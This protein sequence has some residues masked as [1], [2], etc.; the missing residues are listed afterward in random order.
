VI[1]SQEKSMRLRDAL[2]LG[3]VLVLPVVALGA[4]G[5][6]ATPDPARLGAG[7]VFAVM[8]L[9]FTGPELGP[10]DTPAR[11]VH[12]SVLFRHESGSPSYLVQGYWDGD[13]RGGVRGGVF[14]V[15]F[16]PTR[17]GRWYLAEVRSNRKELDGQRE[18]S[19]V[20]A[21]P[22]RNHGFWE[23]DGTSA[24]RRWYRRSDGSHQYVVGNTFYS[25]LSETYLDGKPNGS[26]IARDVRGNAAYFKKLRFSP[27][28]DRYPAPH[29]APF[30]DDSGR[31]TYDGNYSHRP[32]PAWFHDRVDVAV[33]TAFDADLIADLIAS[34]VDTEDARSALRPSHNG[35]DAEPFLR[36][37]A[38]RYGAY[39]NVWFCLINEY[40]IQTPHYT[41]DEIRALGHRLRRYLPYPTPVSVHR[42][43]GPWPTALNDDPSWNDH[44][45]V[46]E[47]LR[48]LSDAADF[49]AESYARGGAD[50][51]VID[52]ELSYQGAG[53]GHDELDTIEAHLGAFLG[54]GYGTTGYKSAN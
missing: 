48:D 35:G 42:S 30:L 36:Y 34:G 3:A 26:D 13:G 19:Y 8:E 23:V 17:P 39:P 49:V 38:A 16:T 1:L 5:S 18:D 7:P 41:A 51:P 50:R 15:R 2:V 31:P 40:D 43:G 21:T 24:G 6:A 33:R 22:S 46:Q 29:A 53:D 28:G 9:T 47:K 37:L 52:D 10:S 44:V 45:I 14:R 27:I 11:D 12:F 4:G 25:F 20:E 54:G 32:N